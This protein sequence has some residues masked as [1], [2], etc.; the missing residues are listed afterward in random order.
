MPRRARSKLD[1][2]NG[3]SNLARYTL[4]AWNALPKP[5]QVLILKE[6][7]WL[8]PI[9]VVSQI[10]ASM[11]RDPALGDGP[12]R[13]PTPPAHL[14]PGPVVYQPPSGVSRR[15]PGGIKVPVEPPLTE[16]R[17]DGSAPG[18][19]RGPPKREPQAPSGANPPPQASAPLPR[20]RSDAPRP[21]AARAP[22]SAPSSRVA[23]QGGSMSQ[24]EAI[25][26]SN[27][28]AVATNFAAE[29]VSGEP[30]GPDTLPY[31]DDSGCDVVSQWTETQYPLVPVVA[32]AGALA[33]T[34]WV[35]FCCYPLID[36]GGSV[37]KLRITAVSGTGVITWTV[38]TETSALETS[39]AANAAAVR[40]V[41]GSL[42]LIDASSEA[43]AGGRLYSGRFL[44]DGSGNGMPLDALALG[45]NTDYW[46]PSPFA[47]QRTKKPLRQPWMYCNPPVFRAPSAG[48]FTSAGEY[49]IVQIAQLPAYGAG[50]AV[51]NELMFAHEY[52]K[53]D[54]V[55]ATSVAATAAAPTV[56][57]QSQLSTAI[58]LISAVSGNSIANAPIGSGTEKDPSRLAAAIR[59]ALRLARENASWLPAA[60]R[61]GY[62]ML[63]DIID[64][65]GGG[66]KFKAISHA[67]KPE[68]TA[69]ALGAH[70][71]AIAAGLPSPLVALHLG[72]VAGRASFDARS[73]RV[74]LAEYDRLSAAGQLPS[75]DRL[76]DYIPQMPKKVGVLYFSP[77][78]AQGQALERRA[79][80]TV[81]D[82]PSSP[83]SGYLIDVSPE[84]ATRNR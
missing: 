6:E 20:V 84:H 12:G 48:R 73:I 24:F 63:K 83:D 46:M 54:Y 40:Y 81:Y 52:A 1:P 30:N 67:P 68:F 60:L 31:P 78:A 13:K 38:A 7:P 71:V 58:S 80:G 8:A 57:A 56:D 64:T 26:E 50:A 28:N 9:E 34:R 47:Q 44:I 77:P 72:A 74:Y 19:S 16:V 17:L 70:Y 23:V 32:G 10:D 15:G 2:V 49:A 43:S 55:P 69:K 75:R 53:F 76:L 66:K 33:G 79:S 39:I 25:E 29:L 11:P 18:L 61:S 82:R 21:R 59:E 3:N 14:G 27:A 37:M 22:V 45:A 35:G 5:L 36:G 4:D 65:S 41:S 51:F 42:A 62:G